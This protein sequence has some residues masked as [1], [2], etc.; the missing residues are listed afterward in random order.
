MCQL[1][2]VFV[3]RFFALFFALS[4]FAELAPIL[5][6]LLPPSKDRSWEA[7]VLLLLLGTNDF[8]L[9]LRLNWARMLPLVTDWCQGYN[10]TFRTAAV[11]APICRD[12][13]GGGCFLYFLALFWFLSPCRARARCFWEPEKEGSPVSRVICTG[14]DRSENG[15]L[16]T[17]RVW[18]QLLMC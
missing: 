12:G 16:P 4:F 9:H 15:S 5:L 14:L 2:N 10:R 13:D 3:L 17:R 1:R 8:L 18:R 6:V 7:V 11:G